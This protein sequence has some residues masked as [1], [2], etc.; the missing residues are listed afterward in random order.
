M[1]LRK[2]PSNKIVVHGMEA[3]RTEFEVYIDG[4]LIFSK[5]KEGY[6]PDLDALVAEVRAAVE[7]ENYQVR[8]VT[9]TESCCTFRYTSCCQVS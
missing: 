1:M 2:C 6:F 9:S 4:I 5:L 8:P 3:G 7:D